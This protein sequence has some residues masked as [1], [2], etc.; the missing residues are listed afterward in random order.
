MGDYDNGKEAMINLYHLFYYLKCCV[1][2]ERRKVIS[3]TEMHRD[4]AQEWC[5]AILGSRR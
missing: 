3:R 5:D 1:E 2:W 4:L